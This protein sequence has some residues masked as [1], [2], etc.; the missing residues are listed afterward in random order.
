MVVTREKELGRCLSE[1][2]KLQLNMIN[3][4][5]DRMYSMMN[6]INDPILKLEVFLTGFIYSYH[7]HGHTHSKY[8]RR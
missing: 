2:I 6:I 1:G 8:M 3:K 5:R 7:I 4:S